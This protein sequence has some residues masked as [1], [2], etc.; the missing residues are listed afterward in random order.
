MITN[1]VDKN[2]NELY[3]IKTRLTPIGLQICVILGDKK[4]YSFAFFKKSEKRYHARMR[5]EAIIGGHKVLN[6][7][8]V[9]P[10]EPS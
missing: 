5:R 6:I 1:I 3:C 4:T 7:K 9:T 10:C 8:G 2:S